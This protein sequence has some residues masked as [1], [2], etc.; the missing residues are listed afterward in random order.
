MI[1]V[2]F[3]TAALQVACSALGI[4]PGDEVILPAWT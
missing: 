2:T 1:V 4:E 3:A